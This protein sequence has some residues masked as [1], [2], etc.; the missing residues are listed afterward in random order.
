MLPEDALESLQDIV[1][2]LDV[3]L[4][5]EVGT[6]ARSAIEQA[7]GVAQKRMLIAGT[8]IMGLCLVWVFLIK[9]YNVAKMQ[10]TKGRLF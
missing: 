2:S 3:Q 8:A 4:S 7:Y 9:N 10:Q 5:Y 1:G 6:P